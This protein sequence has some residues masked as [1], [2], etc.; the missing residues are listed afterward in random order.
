MRGST[1]DTQVVETY[2]FTRAMAVAAREFAPDLF[3]ITGP[4][5]TLGGAVAQSLILAEWRGMTSKQD[6]QTLQAQTPL[7]AAMGMPEQRGLAQSGA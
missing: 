6:F 4:G 3:I 1:L 2:D 7:L 5:T